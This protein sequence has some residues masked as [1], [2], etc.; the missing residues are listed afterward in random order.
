MSKVLWYEGIHFDDYVDAEN[1]NE[2]GICWSYLCANHYN[3][4]RK[5]FPKKRITDCP[6]I[7]ECSVAGCGCQARY[8]LDVYKKTAE[9][10][11]MQKGK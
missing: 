2:L 1:D 5:M 10:D 4:Y 7:A 6:A 3:K 9:M 8:C 11:L